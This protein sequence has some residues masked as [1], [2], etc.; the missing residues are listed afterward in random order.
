MLRELFEITLHI[1]H[2][3]G[4]AGLNFINGRKRGLGPA[5]EVIC[6]EV[7]RFR[8]SSKNNSFWVKVCGQSRRGHITWGT[9][10]SDMQRV[11]KFGHS[12]LNDVLSLSNGGLK[13]RELL[14]QQLLLEL[15]LTTQLPPHTHKY[16]STHF[17]TQALLQKYM[18]NILCF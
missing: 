17:K 12:V 1:L 4:V 3:L 7:V 15:F 2:K 18:Q 11:I 9:G 13:E 14:L 5:D 10:A 16:T 6:R 8:K